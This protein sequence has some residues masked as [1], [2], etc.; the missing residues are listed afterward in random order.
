MD[1]S[2]HKACDL[3]LFS[4]FKLH[5]FIASFMKIKTSFYSKL[6]SIHHLNKNNP[7]ATGKCKLNNLKQ[8]IILTSCLISGI[9]RSKIFWVFASPFF[10]SWEQANFFC[11]SSRSP[12]FF[13]SR[14]SPWISPYSL[15]IHVTNSP[16]KGLCQLPFFCPITISLFHQI[17]SSFI[18]MEKEKFVSPYTCRVLIGFKKIHV[19][20]LFFSQISTYGIY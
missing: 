20:T 10:R 16:S 18:K 9:F 6:K 17:L 7:Q 1:L 5:I 4:L 13:L 19:T 3:N 12:C 2:K 14:S 11:S 15:F 8:V